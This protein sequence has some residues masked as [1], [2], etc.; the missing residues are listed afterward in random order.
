M[1][2][3]NKKFKIYDDDGNLIGTSEDTKGNVFYLNPTIDTYLFPRFD[4]VWLWHK[5]LCRAN[6]ENMVEVCRKQS[7]KRLIEFSLT[8]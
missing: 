7:V 2:F 5:R 3:K 6:F 8:Q 1:E 4:D